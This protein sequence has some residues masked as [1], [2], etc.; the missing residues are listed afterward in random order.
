MIFFFFLGLFYKTHA[1]LTHVPMPP[2]FVRQT[3]QKRPPTA[4]LPLNFFLDLLQQL[5]RPEE[6]LQLMQRIFAL[7]IIPVEPKKYFFLFPSFLFLLHSVSLLLLFRKK[8]S[9]FASHQKITVKY[10]IDGAL[11]QNTNLNHNFKTN[12]IRTKK[13]REKKKEQS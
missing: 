1:T 10:K 11:N 2:Q 5:S 12:Q 7:K 9:L 3:H 8:N 6:L 13:K 4:S